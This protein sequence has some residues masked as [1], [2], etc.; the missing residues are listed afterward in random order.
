MKATIP[1]LAIAAAALGAS[2]IY[3]ALQLRDER[4]R[5]DTLA[6][7][8]RTLDARMSDLEKTRAGRFATSE[9]PRVATAA[10]V[11]PPISQP[12][13]AANSAANL[14]A[15]DRPKSEAFKKMM[16]LN[17]RAYN[18]Q[19]YSDVGAEIGLSKD[20]TGKLIDLL[21]EQQVTDN[22]AGC[23]WMNQ[24]DCRLRLEE[25]R[26]QDKAEI[27]DLIGGAKADA[28]EEYQQSMPARQEVDTIATQ[29]EGADA[30]LSDEQRRRMVAVV[31]EE[32][33]R[34]PAPEMSDQSAS[35]DMGKAFADWQSGYEERV[36][37]QARDILTPEQL[38]AYTGYLQWQKEA[39]DEMLSSSAGLDQGS[40]PAGVAVTT[41]VQMG[42]GDAAFLLPA[43]PK[44][45]P[46]D[47]Q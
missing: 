45:K 8:A 25:R 31:K 3:L 28:L 18:K 41:T 14:L 16:R 26:R 20:E 7:H 43:R 13:A 38:V 6:A 19:L 2:T 12:V 10:R 5:A 37:S 44:E 39:R 36:A 9:T 11:L 4:A 33:N 34:I 24:D 40:G 30:P 42:N 35:G 17:V 15:D 27:V 23:D 32:R 47:P 1:I 21:T 22:A 29:L 46:R